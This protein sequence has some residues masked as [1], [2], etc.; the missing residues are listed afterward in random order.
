MNWL[1]QLLDRVAPEHDNYDSQTH[2]GDF[3]VV[4]DGLV[5]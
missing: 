5:K 3:D 4:F 2:H 1:E